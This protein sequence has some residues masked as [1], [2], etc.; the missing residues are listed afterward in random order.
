MS[1]RI[2]VT[3]ATM[4]YLT[5]LT[6]RLPKPMSPPVNMNA[7]SVLVGLVDRGLSLHQLRDHRCLIPV[8]VEVLRPQLPFHSMALLPMLN[9][10]WIRVLL[11]LPRTLTTSNLRLCNQFGLLVR[12]ISLQYLGTIQGTRFPASPP[13][14]IKPEN[15]NG[16]QIMEEED[17]RGHHH[18]RDRSLPTRRKD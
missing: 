5:D 10:R 16:S 14:L 9:L 4:N 18:T 8:V 13:R 11:S 2:K 6:Y 1:L 12:P 3:L 15:A 17:H 7:N